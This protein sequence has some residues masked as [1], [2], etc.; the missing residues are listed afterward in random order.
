[1]KLQ[2]KNAIFKTLISNGMFDNAHIRLTLTRGK[3]VL[4]SMFTH[5][6]IVYWVFK[7]SYAYFDAAEY[8]MYLTSFCRFSLY[9][10]IQ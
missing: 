3:K 4:L 5:S 7:R 6:N 2:V 10:I 8:L 1:M 9:V